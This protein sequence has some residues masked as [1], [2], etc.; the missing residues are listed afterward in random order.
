[1]LPEK[2][3]SNSRN[4]PRGFTLVELLVVIAIIGI[5]VAL[6]LPAVQSAREAARRTQ[7]KNNL[8]QLGI[9]GHNFHDTYGYFPLGGVDN[10]PIL[11][12]YSS[13]GKLN[14]PL[15]QGLGWAYQL[16]QF[17]E[18]GNVYQR[19]QQELDIATKGA[20]RVLAQTAIGGFNCPS[21]RTTTLGGEQTGATWGG[22]TFYLIDYAAVTAGPTRTQAPSYSMDFDNVLDDP[23]SEFNL[24]W[25]GCRSCRSTFRARAPDTANEPAEFHGITQRCDWSQNLPN[26]PNAYSVGF[27]RKISFAK[28][29]DGS[30]KTLWLGEKRHNPEFYDTGAGYDDRGWCDGW[31]HDLIRSTMYP[32]GPDVTEP[33]FSEQVA[34]R[35]F[36]SAHAAGMNACFA[37]G[38][39]PFIPYDIDREVF[40]QLGNMRD[41]EVT[42]EF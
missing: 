39:V 26:D 42:P 12:V 41:G 8:K 25:W 37:D 4:Q 23:N 3:I 7:C 6:L 11:D 14:G 32:I 13:G 5:L 20:T 38:S 29:S 36:G 34:N 1:M 10:H 21:R 24:L 31:D 15:R 16:L 19:A 9:A 2:I 30:S 17:I 22:W 33:E 28:I 18:E 35:A 40:N 27:T